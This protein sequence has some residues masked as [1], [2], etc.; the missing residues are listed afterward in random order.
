[1]KTGYVRQIEIENKA[2][3]RL[4][5]KGGHALQPRFEAS[6]ISTVFA[7]NQPPRIAIRWV[8]SSSMDEQF[9]WFFFR[10]HNLRALANT[11]FIATPR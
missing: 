7:S 2:I 6:R 4:P 10:S 3:N 5:A 11:V 8:A 9:S 1:L